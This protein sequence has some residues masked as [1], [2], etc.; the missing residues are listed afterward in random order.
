[1]KGERR[2]EKRMGGWEAEWWKKGWKGRNERGRD[3]NR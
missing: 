2:K 1:M 3:P